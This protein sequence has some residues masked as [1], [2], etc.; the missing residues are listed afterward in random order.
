MSRSTEDLIKIVSAGG[1]L[2]L[3]GKTLAADDLVKIAS[4]AAESEVALTIKNVDDKTTEELVSI[5]AAGDCTVVFE[6]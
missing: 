6:L 1:G 3:D 5:A 4:A 2:V